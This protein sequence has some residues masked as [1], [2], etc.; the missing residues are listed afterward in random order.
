MIDHLI[1]ALNQEVDLSAEEIA[2][3][4]WL[5]MHMDKSCKDNESDNEQSQQYQYEQNLDIRL[6]SGI[7]VFQQ[8]FIDEE[9]AKLAF[10]KSVEEPQQ[11]FIEKPEEENK[12]ELYHQKPNKNNKSSDIRY[13]KS[14]QICF[15]C[16]RTSN[17]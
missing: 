17:G 12:A 7:P 14:T 15:L 2:D 5:A 3:T 13:L 6:E 10:P 8:N 1:A 9:S 4:L 16:S 11:Q